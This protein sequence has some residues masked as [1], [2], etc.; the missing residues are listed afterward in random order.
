M[1]HRKRVGRNEIAFFNECLT[2]VNVARYPTDFAADPELNAVSS[3]RRT[4]G[5][6][7]VRHRTPAVPAGT[8]VAWIAVKRP[9]ALLGTENVT[10]EPL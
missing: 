5:Q 4:L 7:P 10:E 2:E 6:H 8:F 1:G 3:P 9:F